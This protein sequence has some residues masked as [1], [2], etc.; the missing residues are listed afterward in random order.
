MQRA[1]TGVAPLGRELGIHWG[2][3]E[4]SFRGSLRTHLLGVEPH[5]VGV[6]A[7]DDHARGWRRRVTD[8]AG[9]ACRDD[10]L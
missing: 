3:L 7:V 9:S 6:A 5:V 1:R 10:H 4:C 8:E 2:G